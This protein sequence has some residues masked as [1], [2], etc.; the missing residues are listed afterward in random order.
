MEIENKSTI[1]EYAFK[2]QNSFVTRPFNEIDATILSALCYF[3]FH[4]IVPK[5]DENKDWVKLSDL[6]TPEFIELMLTENSKKK[7]NLE[8]LSNL[9]ENPRFKNIK[10]NYYKKIYDINKVQ[11]FAAVTFWLNEK[12]QVIAFR[13]TDSTI[14]GWKEN[15]NMM[16][17]SPVPA[18]KTAILYTDKVAS[19]TTG[20]LLLVGHSKGGNLATYSNAFCS[21]AIYKRIKFVYNL[22]GPS[23]LWDILASPTSKLDKQGRIDF[24]KRFHKVIKLIPEDSLIGTLFGNKKTPRVIKSYNI[25]ITQH[26]MY[27]WEW[28][29]DNFIYTD[30][31]DDMK[32]FDE[33]FNEFIYSLTLTQRKELVIYIFNIIDQLDIEDL[34]E[35]SIY[36]LISNAKFRQAIDDVENETANNLRQIIKIIFLVDKTQMSNFLFDKSMNIF[37]GD[38]SK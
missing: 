27:S 24:I 1:I 4:S 19:K 33:K 10:L 12:Q 25:G 31:S 26:S 18:Q 38:I 15:L 20:Q 30:F 28:K 36:S 34:S 7:F 17:N 22:D 2:V 35:F 13:G 29:N 21:E 37:L 9:V 3:D 23:F 11:Q 5:L 32:L 8:L 14:T 16:Y 6:N